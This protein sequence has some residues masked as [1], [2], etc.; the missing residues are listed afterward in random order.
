VLLFLDNVS[1][2]TAVS[3][4]QRLRVANNDLPFEALFDLT[5]YMTNT[6]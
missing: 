4:R 1:L 5:A 3:I 6:Q 2:R